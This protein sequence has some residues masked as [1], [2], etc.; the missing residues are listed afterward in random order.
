MKKKILITTFPYSRFD[1]RPLEI[2]KKN[3]IEFKISRLNRKYTTLELANEIHKYDGLISD[4]ENIN[5]SV[6]KKANKLKII[7]RVG[8][9]VD[10]VDL[11][12]AKKY[13]V[14]VT[15][16]PD[17]PSPAAADLAIGFMFAALR[18][19]FAS[20]NKMHRGIWDR[21]FGKRIE[22][23]TIG[24]IGVGRIGKIV[25]TKLKKLGVK[26]ILYNDIDKRIRFVNKNVIATTKKNVFSQSDIVSIH[27]PANKRN[28]NL[29]SNK[30]LKLMKNDSSLINTSRGEVVNEKD[31]YI[32]LKKKL[33]KSACLDVFWKEPYFGQLKNLDNCFLTA[34]MGSMTFDCR[35]RMEI[36]ATKQ[37]CDFLNYNKIKNRV[38]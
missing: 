7:S 25:I 22:N 30:F 4:T 21:Y 5:E 11:K 31:L 24:I 36:E 35:S 28:H 13:N 10:N 34:H 33:L 23:S 18:S 15:N 17:A 19:T 37:I 8:I 1:K 3:N 16:T 38:V 27:I 6:F 14:V 26:K 32:S 20:H 2:L 29:I 9:G 12:C